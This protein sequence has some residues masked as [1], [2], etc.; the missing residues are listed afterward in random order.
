MPFTFQIFFLHVSFSTFRCILSAY[1]GGDPE[2]KPIIFLHQ[3]Q[4]D[5]YQKYLSNESKKMLNCKGVR[6][7]GLKHIH[8]NKTCIR[9]KCD[10]F[11]SKLHCIKSIQLYVKVRSSA[12]APGLHQT[13]SYK[14]PKMTCGQQLKQ[15]NKLSKLHINENRETHMN[16]IYIRQRPNNMFLSS[17]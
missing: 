14:G 6:E 11:L 7:N 2:T 12:R 9:D 13:A 4:Q 10:N 5:I 17:L 15:K 8:M 3:L 16:H 1:Y